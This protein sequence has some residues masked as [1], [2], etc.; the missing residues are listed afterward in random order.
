[1]A[2]TLFGTAGLTFGFP[3]A[4]SGF[5]I[6]KMEVTETREVKGEVRDNNGDMKAKAYSDQTFN[7]SIDGVPYSATGIGA[8]TV[9]AALTVASYSPASGIIIVEEISTSFSNTDYKR[10]SIKA[11]VHPGITT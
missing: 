7:I 11:V 2:E 9:A 10:Q 6:E 1:M 8:A 4:E 5:L 3:S